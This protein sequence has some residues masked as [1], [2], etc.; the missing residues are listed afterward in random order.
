MFTIKKELTQYLMKPSQSTKT[1]PSNSTTQAKGKEVEQVF[2]SIE[3]NLRM[4]PMVAE[5]LEPTDAKE[6]K[7]K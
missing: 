6:R 1:D 2:T 5:G 7:R 4:V 3:K